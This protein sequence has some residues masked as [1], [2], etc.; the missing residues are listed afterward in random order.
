MLD[1]KYCGLVEKCIENAKEDADAYIKKYIDPIA[2][3]GNPEKLLGKE[4]KWWT[5]Q[6]KMM[7]RQI[8]VYSPEKLEEFMAK[9]EVDK[10]WAMQEFDKKLGV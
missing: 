6:D 7:L 5:E 10:L 1:K 8:Y 9:Q 3:I 2:D 4:Y